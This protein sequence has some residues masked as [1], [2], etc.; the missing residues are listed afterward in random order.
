MEGTANLS[1]RMGFNFI[2]P[3]LAVSWCCTS[4][5]YSELPSLW[6]TLTQY[7]SICSS[8][9]PFA[10]IITISKAQLFPPSLI[11]HPTPSLPIH[12]QLLPC[13]GAR[14]AAASTARTCGG[15]T[16]LLGGT[17]PRPHSL[18]LQHQVPCRGAQVQTPGGAHGEP[19]LWNKTRE[20]FF[21]SPALESACEQDDLFLQRSITWQKLDRG[22]L[23]ASSTFLT[24]KPKSCPISSPFSKAWG[25]EE[26]VT[27]FLEAW[28]CGERVYFLPVKWSAAT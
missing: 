4:W 20:D 13:P 5:M 3:F 2:R 14:A 6:L 9:L 28:S 21:S 12:P 22:L 1:N 16:F 15:G 24:H 18:G 25:H 10:I 19:W 26:K 7:V 27:K 8:L 23:Q 17:P 11:P